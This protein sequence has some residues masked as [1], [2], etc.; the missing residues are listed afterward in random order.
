M[1]FYANEPLIPR[2]RSS[3]RVKYDR[4]RRTHAVAHPGAVVVELGD[5][6]VA[7]GAVFGSDRLP[8]LNRKCDRIDFFLRI[9]FVLAY[10]IPAYQAS[11]AEDAEIQ[12]S[13]L[14]Q[15]HNSLE[16]GKK[17]VRND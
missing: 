8:Y 12:A 15:L 9:I 16:E 4:G 17:A 11:A 10:L 6:A 2:L 7:H 14:C 3:R 13:R 5:A 1:P